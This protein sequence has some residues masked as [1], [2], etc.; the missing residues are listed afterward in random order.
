MYLLVFNVLFFNRIAYGFNVI[1]KMAERSFFHF[2]IDNLWYF[3]TAFGIST[4]NDKKKC[5][6]KNQKKE[7]LRRKMKRTKSW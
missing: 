4:A 7:N 1:N 6:K 2:H 3:S 5:F